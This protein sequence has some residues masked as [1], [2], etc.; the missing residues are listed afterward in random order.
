[1]L[2]QKSIRDKL[3]AF[4]HYQAAL[5][6]TAHLQ[7]PIPY[8]DLA[9]YLTIDRSAMMTELTKMHADGLIRK[10]LHSIQLLTKKTQQTL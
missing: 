1:M 3:L 7:M 10:E 8:S 5:Q 9:D 2:Q 6:N 4:L